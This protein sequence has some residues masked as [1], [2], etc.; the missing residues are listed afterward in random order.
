M[1]NVIIADQQAVF[2]AG[3]AKVLAVEEDI[4][5]V[6]QPTLPEQLL[7]S[8]EKLRTHVLVLA[9]SY[10]YLYEQIRQIASRQGTA[11]LLIADGDSPTDKYLET[12]VLG[13]VYRS[14]NAA[15]IVRA[16]RLVARGEQFVQEPGPTATRW[17]DSVGERVRN[18]LSTRELR[19]VA[20]LIR[21]YKN[22]EI[23]ELVGTSEQTVKNALRS[24]YDKTGVSDRLELA[25]FVLHHRTLAQATATVRLRPL[26]RRPP[27]PTPGPPNF[28]SPVAG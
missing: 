21:G 1:I 23:A 2:R 24:I 10:L 13:V 27:G 8:L 14:V 20:A 12:G 16:V 4:R 18:R 9:T 25:L 19:V 11:L 5:I 6:G 17:E 7:N 3:T 22:R 28:P 15:T 26:P